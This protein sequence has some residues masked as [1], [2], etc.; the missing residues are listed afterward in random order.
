MAFK[1]IWSETANE[2]LKGIIDYLLEHWPLKSAEKF[3]TILL[4]KLETLK[5]NPERGRKS[6]KTDSIRILKI[7][8]HNF[9]FI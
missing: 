5:D 7:D 3:K 6:T 4:G 9:V 2:D 8:K 1:I